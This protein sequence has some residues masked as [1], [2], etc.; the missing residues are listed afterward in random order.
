MLPKEWFPSLHFSNFLSPLSGFRI[1]WATIFLKV[2]SSS[3]LLC[4][5]CHRQLENA[6]EV[7][8][9]VQGSEQKIP[10]TFSPYLVALFYSASPS[11]KLLRL[12][13]PRR[14]TIVYMYSAASARVLV[15]G[16]DRAIPKKLVTYP[17][18]SSSSS[19]EYGRTSANACGCRIAPTWPREWQKC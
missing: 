6:Y 5:L 16:T 2:R 15:Y 3:K 10:Q 17:P 14:C 19:G 9:D 8:G 18:P 13:P 12:R 4:S 7:A 1:R 11:K